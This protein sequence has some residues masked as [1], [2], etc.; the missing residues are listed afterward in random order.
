MSVEAFVLRKPVLQVG[1][2]GLQD[3]ICLLYTSLVLLEAWNELG[4][5]SYLVPTVGDGTSYTD[6]LAAT[7]TTP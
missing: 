5:G 7:L 2:Y 4:E 6:S 3:R 1:I